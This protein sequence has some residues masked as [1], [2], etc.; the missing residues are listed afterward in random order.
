MKK[1]FI[2]ALI[3][4]GMT[5]GL[6][7]SGCGGASDGSETTA[8]GVESSVS[9]DENSPF[10]KNGFE[11]DSLPDG[12]D[13]GGKT[14]NIYTHG[15]NIVSEF[16]T[17]ETGDIV[18][19][20]I[21][22]RNRAIEERLNVKL[23]YLNNTSDDFWGDREIY[24]NT[25]RESVMANDGS[26]DIVA[27]VSSTH[28]APLANEGMFLDLLGTKYLDLDKPW[29]PAKLRDE[30]TIGDK[31]YLVSG[32]A[33]LGVIKGMMC[34]FFNKKLIDDL[35]LE[36]PYELVRN[37]KWTIDKMNEM[38]KK[39]VSDLDGDSKYGVNDQYGLIIQNINHVSNFITGV[40]LTFST[41]QN[42]VRELQLGTEAVVNVIDKVGGIMAQ[43]GFYYKDDGNNDY[44]NTFLEGRAMFG[45]GE[46]SY[47]EQYR[48]V[49][50]D[51]GIIPFPM[52]EESG[53][54]SYYSIPRATYTMFG[55]TPSAD[56]DLC[57]AV[58]EALASENYRSVT[59]VYYEKAL[60]VKYSRDD[61]SSQMFDL[62]RGGSVFD[63][64]IIHA[65]MIDSLT[66]KIRTFVVRGNTGWASTWASSETKCRTLL[67][68]IMKNYE[69]IGR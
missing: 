25:V 5:P 45:T 51:F 67:E 11:K 57:S 39:G 28:M 8:G 22:H 36:S 46:F 24:K 50:F 64:A 23:N 19:D 49:K 65:D 20:A 66:V 27:G 38:A 68:E 13:F 53:E 21:Y 18:D 17:E 54:P 30:L 59:P 15:A 52:M 9:G 41:V 31:M 26:M 56:T 61:V 10:D 55:V 29:W 3:L 7:L 47:T 4:A 12:L 63:F 6:L 37:G 34:F 1:R 33:S 62:I 42:G 43:D 35:H 60:K 32:D 14:V 48:D 40:G 44:A 69:N 58:L 2:A 16:D